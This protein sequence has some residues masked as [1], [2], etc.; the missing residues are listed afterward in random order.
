MEEEI[1]THTGSTVTAKETLAMESGKDI[2]I[3]G[4]KA[5]GKKVEVK[6]GNNLSIESLQDSHTY[7]SRDK[8]SGIHLQRDIT[9]RPDT[10]K[11]KMADPYFSIGKKTDTTD[12]TYESVTEQA[13]IY[14][15]K[16]GYDIQV[17]NNTRLKGAIIDSKA[18]AEKNK[19]TTGTLTWEN[20][21]NKAEYK[22]KA[23]GITVSTN[24][25]SKLNPLGLGYVPTIPVKGK[26][27][28]ITY[29]A[30]ADSIITTTKE[31]T[32]KEISHD[33]TNALNTLSEIFDKKKIE[34]KQEYVNILSQVGYRLIGDIAGHKENELYKKAEKARK[35]NNSILAEKYEKEAKKWSESGTNR[36]A[37]H[38]IMGALVSKEAGAGMTKGLTGAGLNAILQKELGKIKDKEVH[39]MASAAIGYLAGGKTGAAIAHQATTFNYLTH[40]QYEQYLDDM[41]NAKTEE[42]KKRLQKDWEAIDE[43]QR[44]SPIS[45]PGTYWDL[46]TGRPFTVKEG[47]SL[48]EPVL[49]TATRAHG[50]TIFES[51][52]ASGIN[53]KVAKY[54]G[55]ETVIGDALTLPWDIAKDADINKYGIQGA[56]RRIGIDIYGN[57][58][59]VG[60]T[61]FTGGTFGGILKGLGVSIAI[62]EIKEYGAPSLTVQEREN[63]DNEYIEKINREMD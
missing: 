45:T 10:G 63:A 19:L 2:D 30:I 62:E 17:K 27:G 26:A 55:R 5:G 53:T 14:A 29:A 39:K 3:K 35:E 7:H 51:A 13:G 36:I 1:M 25:V 58:M 31:K 12:S 32:D 24:A 16:E 38:G 18:P 44:Y 41:K 15:G 57:L 28:S 6:T 11:K 50:E 23:S 52:M 4:S 48:F 34:E 46:K 42:E 22:T 8:E 47:G 43:R 33:T 49:V 21:D 9:A 61:V 40:E 60:T 54:L 20:I 56:K 59:V 37:M